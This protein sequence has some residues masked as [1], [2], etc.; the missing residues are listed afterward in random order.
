MRGSL[1]TPRATT[2]HPTATPKMNPGQPSPTAEGFRI[3]VNSDRRPDDDL[4]RIGK[5][6]HI[7]DVETV[8]CVQYH[9][10]LADSRA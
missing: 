6:A 7:R 10:S 8:A 2:T 4:V 9:L 1:L 3:L 5:F